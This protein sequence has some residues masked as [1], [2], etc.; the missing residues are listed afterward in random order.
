MRPLHLHGFGTSV[1]VNGR[2][3][4]A[5]LYDG[6]LEIEAPGHGAAHLDLSKGARVKGFA[7]ETTGRPFDFYVM[8]RPNYVEF[9]ENRGGTQILEL[10]DRT[11]LEF[12]RTIPRTGTWYFVA[13]AFDKQ[14]DREV[15]LEIRT[16]DPG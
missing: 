6:V 4:E 16:T 13:D 9:C 15:E 7:R 11:T 10:Y 2:T 5:V 8:D 1:R 3:L 14:N 12:K